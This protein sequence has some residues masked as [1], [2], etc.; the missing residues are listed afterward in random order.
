MFTLTISDIVL[1]IEFQVVLY[2]TNMEIRE[3]NEMKNVGLIFYM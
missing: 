2:Y 1:L 3:N